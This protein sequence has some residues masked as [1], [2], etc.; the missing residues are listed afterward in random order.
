MP[1]PG[2]SESV[3]FVRPGD[4]VVRILGFQ[5]LCSHGVVCSPKALAEER[6]SQSRAGV[7]TTHGRAWRTLGAAHCN[8]RPRQQPPAAEDA[9]EPVPVKDRSA[10]IPLWQ[11]LRP[12]A[13][14]PGSGCWTS[15]HPGRETV[16]PRSWENR[17]RYHRYPPRGTQGD[18][19]GMRAPPGLPRQCCCPPARPFCSRGDAVPVG[20]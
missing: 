19:E 20:P 16:P 17:H 10:P 7:V 15:R 6:G 1:L 3:A 8:Q 4:L 14:Q 9:A 12:R 13:A 11:W 2:Q 5:L 18:A